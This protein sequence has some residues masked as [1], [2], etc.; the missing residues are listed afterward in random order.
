MHRAVGTVLVAVLVVFAGC[1]GVFG[2]GNNEPVET[3]TPAPEPTPKPTPTPVPQLA[4]GL[5][6]KGIENASVLIAAHTSFLQNHSFTVRSNRT[7]IAPNGSVI[8]ESA[9]TFHVGPP[10]KGFHI[11]TK[12]NRSNEHRHSEPSAIYTELWSNGGR[13]FVKQVLANGTMRYGQLRDAKK[14]RYSFTR[15]DLSILIS[16]DNKTTTIT[17]QFTR[18]GTTLYRVRGF[19]QID[20]WMNM[21]LQLLVD[22]RGVIHKIR[23]VRKKSLSSNTTIISETRFLNI[24]VTEVSERPSWVNEAINQ[25]TPIPKGTPTPT[26]PAIQWSSTA[27]AQAG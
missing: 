2:G 20:Q 24:G 12:E 14:F 15:M 26:M 22:S 5:T 25:T 19:A 21:S 1:N 8:M 18:N 7:K 13:V 16:F 10:G 11:I 23:I 17:E 3:F 27:S 9:S 4:P 6:G